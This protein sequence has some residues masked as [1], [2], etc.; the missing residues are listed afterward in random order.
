MTPG[1]TVPYLDEVRP[2][3]GRIGLPPP[4]PGW[5][6]DA[7]T[8]PAVRRSGRNP[9][10]QRHV[11]STLNSGIGIHTLSVLA[12]TAAVLDDRSSA[13]QRHRDVQH[14][15]RDPEPEWCCRVAVER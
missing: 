2:G 6:P 11:Q 10:P 14:L 9:L 5:I 1:P 4:C 12:R 13:P 8:R 3:Q 15:L 7:P